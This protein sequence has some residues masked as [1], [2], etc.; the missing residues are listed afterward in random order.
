MI[1]NWVAAKAQ[2]LL[3]VQDTELDE[4]SA[5]FDVALSVEIRRFLYTQNDVCTDAGGTTPWMKEVEQRMEQLPRAI[6]D[7]F[8]KQR[9]G[10]PRAPQQAEIANVTTIAEPALDEH[11]LALT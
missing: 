9:S 7:D 11:E 10:M 5:N 1:I 6:A 8:I 2:Q 4:F 3:P